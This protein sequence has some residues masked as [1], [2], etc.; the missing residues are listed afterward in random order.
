MQIKPFLV[1][2]DQ[3]S[4]LARLPHHRRRAHAEEGFSGGPERLFD[5]LAALVAGAAVTAAALLAFLH[6]LPGRV[7]ASGAALGGIG[8]GADQSEWCPRQ[9][10]YGDAAGQEA[11]Y[12]MGVFGGVHGLFLR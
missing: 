1:V 11:L 3:W 6:D 7:M 4:G 10:K 8:R 12:V 5:G 9:E 2:Q